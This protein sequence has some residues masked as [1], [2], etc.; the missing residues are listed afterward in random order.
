MELESLQQLWNESDALS[1][2]AGRPWAR[3]HAFATTLGR[4]EA[5]LGHL[6]RLLWVELAV[7]TLAALWLGSF[8]ADH[9]DAMRFFLP[10]LGLHLGV[11][12][13]LG[14]TIRQL[15]ALHRV[16]WGAPVVGIQKRLASLRV[17][18]V[19]AVRWTL[20]AAPL[21]W[22]PLLIVTLEGLLD[23][24]IW[25]L[26]GGA[27]LAANVAFG[28]AVLAGGL[29]LSRR[30]ATHPG[31]ARLARHLAGN[32]LADAERSLASLARFE[33]EDSGD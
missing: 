17:E 25:R 29:L 18:R 23:L 20:L 26:I 6:R 27:W 13:L 14:L 1:V 21:A 10:A 32:A 11:I 30:F 31:A 7:D 19:R 9:F 5:A 8:L 22:T 24:D 4:A 3:L 2:P 15:V 28:V 16:D 33:R 12:A